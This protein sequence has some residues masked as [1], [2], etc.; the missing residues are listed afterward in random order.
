MPNLQALGA[1]DALAAVR[2]KAPL[3]H[4]I[5]NFVVMNTTA[6]ALLAL[7]ASP[8]MAHAEAEMADMVAL[9][10]ALVLNLG[11]LTPAWVA[12]MVKAGEAAN[13][14]GIPIVLDPVGA[15]A[16]PYRTATARELLQALRP[17]ILRGNASEI[18][19]VAGEQVRTKGV[20]ATSASD[21]ALAAAQALQAAYGCAVAVSGPTDHILGGGRAWR[22]HNGH[23]LM[24]RVT[25]LGCTATALCGA[26]AAVTPDPGTAAAQAMAVMGVAG[27]IAAEGAQ[28][29]GTLQLAFLDALYNLE[30]ATLE[31]RLR[32]DVR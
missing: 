4:N 3:V 16:T 23:P 27:E 14:K 30:P 21:D 25:G 31:A 2:A 7:G 15:G 28:G 9:A 8:V 13:A 1:G 22:I 26:F 12:A 19:A 5:T 6:N 10:S 24:P 11:T 18:Q 20:D 17:A 29:P 32:A